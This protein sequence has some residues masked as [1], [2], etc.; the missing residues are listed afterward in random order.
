MS[1][2]GKTVYAMRLPM[3]PCSLPPGH[4]GLC[5]LPKRMP[6]DDR[7]ALLIGSAVARHWARA[8]V[9]PKY[10]REKLE[11]RLVAHPLSCVRAALAGET[12]PAQLGI[13][14]GRTARL[15]RR[16]AWRYP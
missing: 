4:I 12:D 6:T 14:E 10:A 2:C 16:I 7:R 1:R 3:G 15:I 11:W 9:D 5:L 8:V 13:E